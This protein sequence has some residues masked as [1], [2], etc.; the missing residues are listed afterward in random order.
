VIEI[1]SD[2]QNKSSSP[3][4]IVFMFFMCGIGTSISVSAVMWA[5]VHY[6]FVFG[7]VF[8]VYVNVAVYA[9]LVP[10]AL[11]PARWDKE[12]YKIE[13]NYTHN[14]R[15]ETDAQQGLKCKAYKC[16]GGGGGV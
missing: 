1:S 5:L 14:R 4:E 13:R 15:G 11:F 16:G 3:W 2:K 8:F 12:S 9:P 6:S 7:D 10:V